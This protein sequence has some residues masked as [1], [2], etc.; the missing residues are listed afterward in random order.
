ME[1]DEELRALIHNQASEHEI[2]RNL[3]AGEH[4]DLRQEGLLTVEEG[5]STLEEVLRVTHIEAE[6][7][8]RAERGGRNSAKKQVAAAVEPACPEPRQEVTAK[9]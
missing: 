7:E 3:A 1:V 4:M 8:I 6:A 5:K 2:R 9:V